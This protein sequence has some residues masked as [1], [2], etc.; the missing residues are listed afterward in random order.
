MLKQIALGIVLLAGLQIGTAWGEEELNKAIFDVVG[1]HDKAK[2]EALLAKG[3]DV[4]ARDDISRTPLHM[5]AYEGKK[6]VAEL[7][8]SKGADVNA[9]TDDGCTPL[10]VAVWWGN[11]KVTELLIS[12]GAEVNV[13]NKRGINP[14]I[15]INGNDGSTP[16]HMASY[17]GKT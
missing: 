15:K 9:K 3:A 8:I 12:K 4:N 7:L 17:G 10:H 16:L 13:K 11:K 2:I 14:I 6:E 5:A 1:T